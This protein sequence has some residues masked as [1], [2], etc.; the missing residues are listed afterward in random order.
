LSDQTVFAVPCLVLPRQ[1]AGRILRGPLS[2]GLLLLLHLVGVPLDG[3]VC[4][5][6]PHAR[7]TTMTLHSARRWA[8][9]PASPSTS[10]RTSPSSTPQC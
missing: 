8:S 6:G 4:A 9:S 2:C 5:C 10:L 3:S 1:D 7:V